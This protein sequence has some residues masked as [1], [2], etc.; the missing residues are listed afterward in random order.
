MTDAIIRVGDKLLASDRQGFNRRWNA[1]NLHTVYVPRTDEEVVNAINLAISSQL[2]PAVV[3]GRHCYENFVYNETS[4]AI[5]EMVALNSAGKMDDGRYFIE[6]GCSN[7]HAY[8][9]LLFRHGVTLP[10]GSCYSVGAGGHISGGGYGLLSR[11][12]GLTIDWVTGFDVVV[13][14]DASQPAR[15]IHVNTSSTDNEADLFFA[16]RGAGPG[17]FGLIVRYYFDSLPVAPEYAFVT[18][19]AIPWKTSTG[20]QFQEDELA[21]LLTVWTNIAQ[22]ADPN[23]FGLLKLNHIDASEIQIVVQLSSE[24][25]DTKFDFEARSR[26]YFQKLQSML[27]RFLEVGPPNR[28]VYGHPANYFPTPFN[29]LES[30]GFSGVSQLLTYYE[31]LQTL[32]GEGSNE[33]GKYK[34]AYMLK[35]FTPTMVKAMYEGLTKKV[36]TD[37]GEPVDMSKSLVQIDT[38]GGAINKVLPTE[39][40]IPQRNAVTKLQYQTYWSEFVSD[41]NS[42]LSKA[43]LKW[44]RELY[45]AVYSESGGIPEFPDTEKPEP[46]TAGCYYNYPD[47]D[48]GNANDGKL[49]QALR[50]YF[51]QNLPR[52][53][54]TKNYWNK[55]GYFNNQQ[56]IA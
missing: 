52:L 54:R 56:S 2:N 36:F 35:D 4:T 29:A 14:P 7:W 25:G 30:V 26:E 23:M 6:A 32:N 24:V 18:V 50:L 12:H 38:Y 10:A 27:G 11:L 8:R 48:I 9:E 15:L 55:M 1:P 39:T 49:Q 13:K 5:I 17:N 40:A 21:S 46:T 53:Q 33:S 41:D 42:L 28:P 19:L 22:N 3:S 44:I 43:H 20:S 45:S 47:I 34:S 31:A 16:L 51:G 37:E